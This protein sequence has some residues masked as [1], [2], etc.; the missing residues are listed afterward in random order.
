[1]ITTDPQEAPGDS[2]VCTPFRD[3][4]W[5]FTP[6]ERILGESGGRWVAEKITEK[7]IRAWVLYQVW[8]LE[9]AIREYLEHLQENPKP[10]VW[11][12]DGTDYGKDPKTLSTLSKL[13]KSHG[14]PKGLRRRHSLTRTLVPNCKSRVTGRGRARNFCNLV[15]GAV[16]QVQVKM[17]MGTILKEGDKAPASR[18]LT[19]RPALS[20]SLPEGKECGAL[21]LPHRPIPRMNERKPDGFV[22]TP[23]SHQS[24]TPPS[25]GV[26]FPDKPAPLQSKF[27]QN[28]I[29]R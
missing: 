20:R 25:V 27:K 28:T 6:T 2:L 16:L 10:F 26:F 15:P 9:K 21:L 7:R 8:S 23:A 24:K 13:T 3:T 14:G 1:V 12:A 17:D 11:T 4:T 22:R 19:I 5:H 29:C 18:G